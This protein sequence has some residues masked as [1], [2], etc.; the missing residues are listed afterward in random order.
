[1]EL[2]EKNAFNKC[3]GAMCS[4]RTLVELKGLPCRPRTP[5]HTFQSYLSGIERFSLSVRMHELSGS[6]RT[7]VELKVDFH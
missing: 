3:A 1:M 4:N 2:K 7:L 5:I 6:N